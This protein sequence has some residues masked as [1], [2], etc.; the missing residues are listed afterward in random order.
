MVK[1]LIESLDDG[2]LVG[3]ACLNKGD[4]G[5]TIEEEAVM[6][7]LEKKLIKVLEVYETEN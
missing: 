4:T 3:S 7:L 1:Y 6:F 5:L 2:V